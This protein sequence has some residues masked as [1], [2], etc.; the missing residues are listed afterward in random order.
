[1]AL[2]QSAAKAVQGILGSQQDL[3]L[4]PRTLGRLRTSIRKEI[5]GIMGEIDKLVEAISTGKDLQVQSQ[6]WQRVIHN[7]PS[8][9]PG[10]NAQEVSDF[11]RTERS[12]W[13]EREL[14]ATGSRK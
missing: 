4:D 3:E 7:K 10:Q 1:M 13:S 8:I 12:H 6:D 14:L 2:G 5:A 11:L 9:T